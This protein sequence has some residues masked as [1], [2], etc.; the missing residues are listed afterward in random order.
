MKRL[1]VCRGYAGKLADEFNEGVGLPC[2]CRLAQTLARVA[3]T[4]DLLAWWSMDTGNFS[5]LHRKLDSIALALI[6]TLVRKRDVVDLLG[7]R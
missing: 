2:T 7:V 1:R 5:S 3:C 4:S 6:Q